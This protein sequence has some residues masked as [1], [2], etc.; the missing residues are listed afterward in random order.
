MFKWA[1]RFYFL[2]YYI[3]LKLVNI[4]CENHDNFKPFDTQLV[5]QKVQI[6]YLNYT[7]NSP[8]S[9]KSSN[10][11]DDL[12]VNF[13]SIGCNISINNNS[14]TSPK[15]LEVKSNIFSVFINKNEINEIKLLVDPKNLNDDDI[16]SDNNNDHGIYNK[17][18]PIVINSL[19]TNDLKIEIEEKEYMAFYF[20]ENISYVELSYKMKNLNNNSFITLSSIY[21]EK[22]T[23]NIEIN[24]NQKR[25]PKSQNIFL[26]YSRLSKIK[27]NTLNITISYIKENTPEEGNPVLIFGLYESNSIS[28]LQKKKLNI[29]F[30]ISNEVKQYYYLEVFKGEEGEIMLHDKRFY[31]E[32]YGVIKKKSDITPYNEAEYIKEANNN[33][34][35][36]DNHTLRLSFKSNE[37]KECEKGCYLLITY[38]HNNFDFNETIGSEFTLLARI[39]GKE[40]IDSEIINI[41]INEYIFGVFEKDSI[42]HHYYSLSIP[43][44][45]ESIAIQFEGNYIDGFIGEGEEKINTLR[46]IDN[47]KNLNIS[48]NKMIIICN[49]TILKELDIKDSISFAFRSKNFFEDT[50]SF[51]YIR[52]LIKEKN[53]NIIYPIDSNIGNICIPEKSTEEEAYFC[54]CHLK[55]NYKELSIENYITTSNQIDFILE[56]KENNGVTTNFKENNFYEIKFNET[57]P[58]VEYKFIFYNNKIVN[59]LSTF[60]KDISEINPQIYSSEMFYLKKDFYFKFYLNQKFS[61]ILNYIYGKGEI[62]YEHFTFPINMNFQGKPLLLHLNKSIRNIRF[63]H[64]NASFQNE[65]EGL[66]FFAKLNYLLQTDEVREINQ[67]ETVSELVKVKN[68]PIYYYLKCEDN[69]ENM[70]INLKIL[71]L[72]NKDK[73]KN[74]KKKPQTF[75]TITGYLINDIDFNNKE[76]PIENFLNK[77]NSINGV[78]DIYFKIGVLN[79]KKSNDTKYILV[80]IDTSSNVFD[81]EMLIEILAISSIYQNYSLLPIN[82]YILDVYKLGENKQYLIKNN[83]NYMKNANKS[84]MVEFIPNCEGM[85]LESEKENIIEKDINCGMVQKYRI[86]KREEDINFK[87]KPPKIVSNCYYLI[88]YFYTNIDSEIKYQ[89]NEVNK[90]KKGR[91][92]NDIILDFKGKEII[93]KNRK[94]ERDFLIYGFLY[95]NENDKNRYINSS[96]QNG[97]VSIKTELDNNNDFNFSLSFNDIQTYDNDYIYYLKI[98]IISLEKSNFF[99]EE[100]LMYTIKIDLRDILKNRNILLIILIPISVIIIIVI[101]F[102]IIMIAM[103]KKNTKLKEKVLAISFTSDNLGE[104]ILDNNKN[105]KKDEDY[106]N[107]F[108]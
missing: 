42:N 105:N 35:K 18:C 82:K 12:L 80:K 20:N 26:D 106:E 16:D 23:F 96:F 61:I 49:S 25:I 104:D 40:E 17:T 97:I 1:M 46:T 71:N 10:E 100:L 83:K 4:N 85:K 108:T 67:G 57:A 77:N 88:R 33:Q 70:N 93:A 103:K 8:F 32:L 50:F 60:Y 75:F 44:N 65:N 73:N 87:V 22:Y 37:T 72:E 99:N 48:E 31:G 90:P 79:I 55:N 64:Y 107:A 27:N 86:T 74:N 14:T 92:K 11:T 84:I 9:F 34:L 69:S 58:Y 51:Y 5:P 39:W 2:I 6:K 102:I 101:I 63:S 13:H 91:N 30:T 56:S 95:K 52:I 41:P 28:F 81:D 66:F 7:K 62:K 15:I 53:K 94:E 54:L 98:K 78:Y 68:L 19:Y 45:T 21:D 89:L 76:S 59:I 36:Y 3:Y 38:T 29:G 47:I 24:D 43:K